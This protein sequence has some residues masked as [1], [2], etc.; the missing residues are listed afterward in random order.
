M[1]RGSTLLALMTLC[2]ALTCNASAD[3][4]PLA[5]DRLLL[6]DSGAPAARR[7]KFRAARDPR[8]NPSTLDDP[9][10]LGAT[11]EVKGSGSK[12]GDTGPLTLDATHWTALGSPPG[13]RGY[14]Y[15]DRDRGAGVKR[16][17]LK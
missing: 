11:L 14:R 7:F 2:A 8:V 15:L 10:A 3:D 9:T 16:V 4:H 12:D 6:K 13:S 1:E 5:G 17:L